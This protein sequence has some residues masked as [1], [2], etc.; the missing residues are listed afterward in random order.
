M[1]TIGTAVM[2]PGKVGAS[3]PTDRTIASGGVFVRLTGRALETLLH[4]AVCREAAMR[5]YRD[6][7]PR[8][9]VATCEAIRAL[10]QARRGGGA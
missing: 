3:A 5:E 1:T 6:A 2:V 7:D 4:L 9:V 10:E 8:E